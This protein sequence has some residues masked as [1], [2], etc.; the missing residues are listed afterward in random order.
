MVPRKLGDGA[1]FS[2]NVGPVDEAR[3]R[4]GNGPQA[5]RDS[6]A[7]LQ[8]SAFHTQI[9]PRRHCRTQWAELQSPVIAGGRICTNCYTQRC[10]FAD[11]LAVALKSPPKRVAFDRQSELS[12]TVR[13]QRCQLAVQSPSQ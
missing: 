1:I 6:A 5:P 10:D 12:C 2:H 3:Y 4:G 7:Q 13:L 11:F 8:Y 9:G